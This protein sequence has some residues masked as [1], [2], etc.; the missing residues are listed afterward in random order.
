MKKNVKID[1]VSDV[2]CPWCYVGKKNLEK[3]LEQLEDVEV[4]MN[5]RPF[6]LDP[7]IPVEGVDKLEYNASKF[8]SVERYKELSQRVIEAGDR[9]GVEFNFDA[10]QRVPNTLKLHNLLYTAQKEGNGKELKSFLLEAFFERGVDL[11]SN[12][13]ILKEM[14][15][16]GW[17]KSKT[18]EALDSQ[19]TAYW[20][21]KEVRYYQELGVS[22]VPFF[23]IDQKY[24]L[25]G[26]QPP[27]AFVQAITE[28]SGKVQNETAEACDIEDPNC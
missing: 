18:Q 24:A 20:V 19:E 10:I 16:Y 9:A 3:A 22:G 5:F 15:D 4:E 11:S 23:I 14:E 26:A 25:S 2:V 6:Q 8:G 27:E 12:E 28:I 7:T 21:Q 17:E 13:S 1:I